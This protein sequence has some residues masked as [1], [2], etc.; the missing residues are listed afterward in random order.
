[1]T[2]PAGAPVPAAEAFVRNCFSA[3]ETHLLWHFRGAFY[4]FTGSHYRE[5]PNEN[6]ER[7]LYRFLHA[8][9]VVSKDGTLAPYNPTRH[10]VGEIVHALRRGCL[11]PRDRDPPFWLK[12]DRQEPAAHLVAVRNG[13]LNIETRQLLA[14]DPLFFTTN[15]L[16]LDYDPS[17]PEPKRW[18]LFLKELWPADKD[19]HYDAEAEETL[20][21]IVGYLLTSDTSQQKI[22]IIIGPPRCGKGTIVYVLE[23]LL[24]EDNC[25]FPTLTSLGGEFGRWPLIDKKLAAITDARIGSADTHRIAEL[26]LSMSGGDRQTINRK[27]QQFWTGHLDVR[28]LMTTNVLPAIHDASGTIA[29]RYILL[30]LTQSFLGREDL[31]L[32]QKLSPE[33]PGI[34]NYALDGLD[35]LRERGYFRLPASAKDSIRELE[36]AAEPVKAFLREWCELRSHNR[37]NVK[38]LYR[39]YRAWAEEAGHKIVA[40]NSFGRALK[41]QLP[42]LRTTGAGA[43]REYIGVALSEQGTECFDT[44]MMEKGR[45]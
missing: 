31:T 29:T 11:V 19:G 23:Q 6:L 27:N 28:F 36:D 2:L 13:I 45:R 10:K 43:K 9:L 39:A 14:H 42:K 41:G 1:V 33:M 38:T 44:I 4:Q 32:K 37:V 5:Y 30:K 22:F 16:P 34:L 3:G 17:A 25:V 7:D 20:Q 18:Q 21:E 40:N 24:G 15:C 26:L 35:R 8:A 12:E